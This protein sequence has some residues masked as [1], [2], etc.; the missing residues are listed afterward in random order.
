MA[1][2]SAK[3][4]H[5]WFKGLST[6]AGLSFN[7]FYSTPGA[8]IFEEHI[9]R[10]LNKT[11]DGFNTTELMGEIRYCKDD[12]YVES[13]SYRY[14]IP[15]T[16]PSFTFRYTYGIGNPLYG[17]YNYHKF[18]FNVRQI[19]YMPIIGYGKLNASAGYI[20]GD[21]P[22]PN[23]FISSSNIGIFKDE[24]SFQ[25]TKPFEFTSDKYVQLWYEQ[26]FEGLLFNHIPY[27]KRLKLREFVSVKAMWGDLSNSNKNLLVVPEGIH[28]AG[29]IPYVEAGFGVENILKVVQLSFI[30]RATYLYTPGAPNFAVKI[31]IKPGF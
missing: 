8:F 30:W 28:T 10:D 17:R 2:Q 11:L 4:E 31:G 5:D 12:Q 21:A 1:V 6:V 9:A 19:I 26:H 29:T 7:R 15:T 18:Q 24:L 27:V 16:K 14:F 25:L 13:Y 23:A 22:Y 3:Y 20:V